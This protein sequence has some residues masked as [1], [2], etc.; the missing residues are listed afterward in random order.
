MLRDYLIE[1]KRDISELRVYPRDIDVN[2][3]YPL[4]IVGPRRAGKSFFLF[5]LIKT[6]NLNE[7]DYLYVNFEDYEVKTTDPSQLLPTHFEIYRREP[8]YLFLDE[9]Q[10]IKN[11]SHFVYSL[12]ERKKYRVILSGSS[13][14]LL[15][16]EVASFLRGRFLSKLLL[17]LSFSEFLTFRNV[18]LDEILSRKDISIVRGY[19]M[20]YLKNGGFPEI[21][22]GIIRKKDFVRQYLDVVLYRDFVE[23]FNIENPE[24]AKFILYS[25]IQS[26]ASKISSNKIYNQ[27]RQITKVSNKTVR[28]YLSLFQDTLVIFFTKKF[29]YSAKKTHL[30]QPKIY[31]CDLSLELEEDGT[32][33]KMENVVFLNLIRRDQEPFYF[34]THEGYEVD[35]LIKNGFR[36]K[37][38][39]QVT[40]A[41]SF[42]EIEHREIRALLHAY[43]VLKEHKPELLVITW[44]YE[45]TREIRW[46][47]K[48]G[49]IRFVPLWKW[50]LKI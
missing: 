36:I 19:L 26:N 10:S 31:L 32:G 22:L 8:K 37:Q 38:L 25:L 42:D 49:K 11:W 4:A 21:V 13:S 50:L 5:H 16:K 29:H 15:S 20:E 17:P 27:L 9:V 30:S 39:I 41:S 23:R 6:L 40:Y 12:V 47:G 45:D 35:F 3:N 24:A 7:E 1:I 33:R 18:M 34:E 48:S 44:D 28:K 46:F 2:V 14:K 43:D